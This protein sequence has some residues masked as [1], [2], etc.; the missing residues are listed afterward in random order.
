MYK[1]A[2][3]SLMIGSNFRPTDERLFWD[4]LMP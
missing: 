3:I 4:F 2:L 1:D